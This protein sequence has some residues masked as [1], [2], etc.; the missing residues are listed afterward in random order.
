M[1]TQMK[2]GRKKPG[3]IKMGF[4]PEASSRGWASSARCSRSSAVKK[5]SGVRGLAFAASASPSRSASSF[6]S[7]RP[8]ALRSR[9]LKAE[10]SISASCFTEAV[11]RAESGLASE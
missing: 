10:V 6:A 11:R 8:S 1:S 7:R 2:A 9:S 5:V 3:T 4:L